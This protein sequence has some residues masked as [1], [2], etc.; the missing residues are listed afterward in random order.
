MGDEESSDLAGL[1][2]T[3][4]E[5]DSGSTGFERR[6]GDGAFSDS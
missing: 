4:V 2:G 1:T 3:C 6:C 5:W